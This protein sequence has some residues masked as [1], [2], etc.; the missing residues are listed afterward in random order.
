MT[1][2]IIITIG[3]ELLIGQ[4]VDT[5]SSWMGTELNK[6]G[7]DVL[8]RI[9]VG[10]NKEEII[11]ALNEALKAASIVLITGGLGPTKDDITK[12][13]L[14]EYFHCGLVTNHD[15]LLD[16]QELFKGVNRPIVDSNFR[17]ADIPE[18]CI[19]IRN[20]VGTAP[21]MWF[22]KDE[23]VIV[24]MPGVPFEMKEMMNKYVLPKLKERFTHENIEHFTVMTFGVGESFLAD[25]IKVWE[26]ALPQNI[27]LAYLPN[28]SQVRLRL[29]GH[30][31]DSIILKQ[32]IQEQVDQLLRLINTSVFAQS[33]ISMEE[34]IGT[35]LK[36]KNKTIA[37]AESCTGGYI[38]HKLTSLAGSSRWYRGS[39]VAYHNDVKSEILNVEEATLKEFG[40]VSEQTVQQMAKTARRLLKSDY[41]IAV[42]GIVGPDGGTSE[43]PVGM[44]W[45]AVADDR[46]IYT[47]QFHF[48]RTR[49]QN[50]EL[51]TLN[52]LFMLYKVLQGTYDE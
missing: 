35:L 1:N 34:A 46:R 32:Q 10:D 5:N 51:A 38:A 52:A 49:L 48:R 4:V 27:K 23:K 3:D 9:A 28:L 6:I 8:R 41:A 16:I 45:I 7:I 2:C 22:N 47:R 15:V 12:S 31:M 40:A 37:T 33:D 26:N 11:Y 21:G 43:K 18:A 36:S 29:T 24:S 44:V 30:G 25:K 14:A 13:T 39:V 20:A 50:I 19:A 17:Q 42:S